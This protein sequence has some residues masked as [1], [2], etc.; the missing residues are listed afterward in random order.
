MI[1]DIIN[2]CPVSLE[3]YDDPVK[4]VIGFKTDKQRWCISITRLRGC[5]GN[6]FVYSLMRNTEGREYLA[7]IMTSGIHGGQLKEALRKHMV[8]SGVIDS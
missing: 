7:K 2:S 6:E 4:R 1:I 3:L 5:R 8:V